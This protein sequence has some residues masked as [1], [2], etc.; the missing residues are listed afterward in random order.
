[1]L[2]PAATYFGGSGIVGT[3]T[4]LSWAASVTGYG[5]ERQADLLALRQIAAASY[6]IG[7]TPR[8]FELLQEAGDAEALE[9]FFYASH[10]ANRTREQYTREL[11]D[12]GSVT[13]APD[14][15]VNREQY[16]SAIAG[17]VLKNI[18]L[19]LQADHYGY[20]LKKAERALER[21]GSNPW[22]YYYAGEAH[23]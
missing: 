11:I 15:R 18:R 8:M 2:M 20:A 16:Q 9:G 6:P 19:R 13:S 23:R 21:D 10:P 5:R 3:L 4:G 1:M 7:Q 14:A 12:S 17:L 22:L